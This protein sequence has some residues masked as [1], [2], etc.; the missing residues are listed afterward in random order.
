[1]AKNLMA[2]L[3]QYAT[4]LLE[5][6]NLSSKPANKHRRFTSRGGYRGPDN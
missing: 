5:L 3:S 1:M 2:V 6:V 4:G